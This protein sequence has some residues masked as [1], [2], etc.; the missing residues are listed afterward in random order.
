MNILKHFVVGASAT[1]S[2]DRLNVESSN[3]SNL[4][5]VLMESK[6][7]LKTSIV[8]FGLFSLSTTS[9]APIL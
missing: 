8:D 3:I 5:P 2:L 6:N 4:E 9:S 1:T 7:D